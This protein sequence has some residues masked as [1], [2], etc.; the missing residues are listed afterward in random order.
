MKVLYT[1]DIHASHTHLFSMLSVAEKEEVDCVIMGGDV[2]PHY[3]PERGRYGQIEAQALYLENTFIPE[4]IDFRN[5][6]GAEIYLDLGND[7]L[8][9]GR[10]IL[11]ECD[12]EL[13][14]LIHFTKQALT[15]EVDI[16]GYMIVPPTPF[17]I[18]D[19]EKPD[20]MKSPFVQGN[21]VSVKGYIS[22]NGILEETV[23]DLSTEDTIESDLHELSRDIDRPFI[24]VSHSP[25]F[26][27]PLDVIYNGNHVGSMSIRKFIEKWSEKGLLIA[28]FHGHIHESPHRSGSIQTIIGDVLCM[29]PG[30]GNGEGAEFRYVVFE[31]SGTRIFFAS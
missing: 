8:I 13:L 11:E 2:V 10:K 7:D 21:R 3:L 30:Q 12:G 4:L 17:T 26:D 18:K 16:V 23:L 14:H 20:S 6:T 1:S 24:F 19:L 25:P 22:S 9:S 31:L 15:D 29:N 27:T 28:A 5:R